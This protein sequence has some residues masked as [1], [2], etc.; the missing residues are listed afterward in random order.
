MTGKNLVRVGHRGAPRELPANTMKGF[1][2][3]AELGCQMVECDVRRSADD[4]LMLAH[5]E[6]VTD[7]N[8]N[9]FGIAENEAGILRSLDL[10]AGE[11]V[12][13]LLE[14]TVWARKNSIAIMADMK[15]EGNGVEEMVAATLAGLPSALKI[16]PGAGAE[17]RRRFRSADRTL[18]LSLSLDR[19]AE[20]ELSGEGLA[21]LLATLDTEAVTWQYPLLTAERIATLQERGLRVFAWTVDETDEM[22]RLRADGVDGIISNRPDLLAAL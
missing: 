6:S 21:R 17:S 11:G 15:V 19:S 4:V 2:R 12:P 14:L 1:V 7:A 16:V 22:N 10:G 8:G 9:T 18:P 5:D 3:A 13:T 20:T